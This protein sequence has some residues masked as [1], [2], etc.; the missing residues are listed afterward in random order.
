V[1]TRDKISLLLLLYDLLKLER[2]PA[3]HKVGRAIE[4]LQPEI[5]LAS[6]FHLV[7]L[8]DILMAKSNGV[9][10]TLSRETSLDNNNEGGLEETW[11]GRRI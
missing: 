2:K 11:V 8:Y 3:K 10:R 7:S 1:K 6:Y 9:E 5:L 4:Q